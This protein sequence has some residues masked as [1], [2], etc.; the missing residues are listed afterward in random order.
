MIARV[1]LGDTVGIVPRAVFDC[2][3]LPGVVC[4]PLADKPVASESEIALLFRRH[5]RSQ[6]VRAFLRH[7]RGEG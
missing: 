7:A 4:R 6:A 5:E 1:S 2:V 3:R